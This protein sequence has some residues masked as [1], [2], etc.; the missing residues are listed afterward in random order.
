LV[1][2]NILIVSRSERARAWMRA[3][4]DTMWVIDEASNGNEALK[5]ARDEDYDLVIT[6]E[7]SE[8][9]GAFGL[10]RELK[11]LPDPPAVVVLLERLVD[12]WLAKWSGADRWLT[13]PIDPFAVATAAR[14]LLAERTPAS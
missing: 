2:V 8:P 3:A 11:I 13:Q 10:A 4:L 14:E 6:D 9:F 1:P 12:V 5:R 7:T